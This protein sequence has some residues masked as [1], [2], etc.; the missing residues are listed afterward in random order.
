MHITPGLSPSSHGL[1]CIVTRRLFCFVGLR[2]AQSMTPN[3]SITDTAHLTRP[4][5]IYSQ[6][7]Q[8]CQLVFQHH[9]QFHGLILQLP[10]ELHF[11]EIVR[12]LIQARGITGTELLL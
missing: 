4:T 12:G 8:S 10:E 3:S 9:F 11:G 5:S 2:C 7:N 1:L 6:I